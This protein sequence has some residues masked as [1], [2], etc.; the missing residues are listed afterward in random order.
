[1]QVSYGFREE[2]FGTQHLHFRWF[3]R[4]RLWE[5]RKRMT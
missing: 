2:S 1:V 5:S 4:I 3:V